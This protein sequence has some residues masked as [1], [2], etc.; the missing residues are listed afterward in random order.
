MTVEPLD[1]DALGAD[2]IAAAMSRPPVEATAWLRRLASAGVAEAQANLGQR[3]LDGVGVDAHPRE[4]LR[5]FLTASRSAH[6]MGLNMAGRC[7]E[8]GW[9]T[10]VNLEVAARYYLRAAEAGSDW[11]MYNYATR[12]MLGEGVA[13]D[14]RAAFRWFNRAARLGHAKSINVI[15]GFHED[16]WETPRDLVAAQACYAEAAR[17][18]DFRGHFNLGRALASRG[19]VVAA[20]QAFETAGRDGPPAFRAQ[21][22]AFLRQAPVMRYHA[23]ADALEALA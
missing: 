6:P 1:L 16:G 8:N 15:G 13:A 18:G 4:A 2:D 19:E 3:L 21:V 14:R 7:Y 12:L 22:T 17:L 20:A 5:W 11:G 9:G 23:V 10:S